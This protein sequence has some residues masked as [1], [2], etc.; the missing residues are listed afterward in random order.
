MRKKLK[1]TSQ[2]FTSFMIL[3]WTIHL[4]RIDF[5]YLSLETA[6][7]I[8]FSSLSVIFSLI[9]SLF[10]IDR[11]VIYERIYSAITLVVLIGFWFL[12]PDVRDY[13]PYYISFIIPVGA[14]SLS[15]FNKGI[16]KTAN[17]EK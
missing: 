7:I 11:H 1:K 16:K 4:F 3:F 2:I 12:L 9:Y 13:Q 6:A 14:F 15:Y 17:D 8:I 5:T 10:T